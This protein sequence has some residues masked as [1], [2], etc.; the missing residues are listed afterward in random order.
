MIP[1][2]RSSSA[3]CLL[4]NPRPTS[5]L[6]QPHHRAYIDNWGYYT[7]SKDIVVAFALEKQQSDYAAMRRRNVLRNI[8]SL[9][10]RDSKGG[11]MGFMY[12]G[13]PPAWANRDCPGRR[14]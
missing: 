14:E 3:K 2:L 7:A 5:A 8:M 1:R 11:D 12:A 10:K 9:V 13:C 6:F 4:P